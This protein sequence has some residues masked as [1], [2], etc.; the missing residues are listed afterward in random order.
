MNYQPKDVV[1]AKVIRTGSKFVVLETKEGIKFIIYK[2]EITDYV[3]TKIQD[4]LKVKDIINFVVLKYDTTRKTGVGSFKRNHP[5][6]MDTPFIY[7]LK[8]TPSGFENLIKN[9]LESL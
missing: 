6:F 2:N 8:E 1:T 5:T 7:R 9:T 3:K 4:I